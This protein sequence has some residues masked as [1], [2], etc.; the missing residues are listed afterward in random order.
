MI[1]YPLIL[2]GLTFL[3]AKNETIVQLGSKAFQDMITNL[4][5]SSVEVY[6][7]LLG[8]IYGISFLVA[9][10][11]DLLWLE[12]VPSINQLISKEIIK[13]IIIGTLLLGLVFT[14]KYIPFNDFKN[15]YGETINIFSIYSS[16][17]IIFN[18]ISL[19]V[20]WLISKDNKYINEDNECINKAIIPPFLFIILFSL[21]NIGVAYFKIFWLYILLMIL[22]FASAIL[23]N[24]N[25][26]L[27]NNSFIS[28]I[29]GVCILTTTKDNTSL[30]LNLF[31]SMIVALYICEWLVTKFRQ[32]HIDNK[33]ELRDI[34]A[35]SGFTG[36]VIV[37]I[38]LLIE[39]LI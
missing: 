6:V 13:K 39:K 18:I 15:R 32:I 22:C 20:E 10:V 1:L 36:S 35:G 30:I 23:Y 19:L 28:F 29:S 2:A 17:I 26:I 21:I 12:F 4:H 38:I 7:N 3:I 24:F 5:N 33:K 34:I 25:R 31:L 37:L 11:I 27:L 16:G 9:V 8:P 14:W